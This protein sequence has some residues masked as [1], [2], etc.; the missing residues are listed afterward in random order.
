M[1]IQSSLRKVLWVGSMATI[2]L[3]AVGF[4]RFPPTEGS[5]IKYV[6]LGLVVATIICGAGYVGIRATSTKTRQDELALRRG[7]NMGWILGAVWVVYILTSHWLV[8]L[9]DKPT[10][11]NL[12]T[13]ITF[14]LTIGLILV[15][16]TLTAWQTHSLWTGMKVGLWEGL[17]VGMVGFLTTLVMLYV[18]MGFL[19]QQMNFGELQA[20]DLSGW[21]NRE[22][23]YFWEEEF[24]GCAGYFATQLIM[25]AVGGFLGGLI[26][27]TGAVLK[28]QPVN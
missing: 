10:L 25:G 22:V 24:A 18:S 6:V 23:W 13:T 4:M 27:R 11:G 15:M 2:L 1:K 12:E 21:H 28:K 8:G 17:I 26:G 19:V 9:A 7:I 3:V 16:S 5:F 14:V 20:F